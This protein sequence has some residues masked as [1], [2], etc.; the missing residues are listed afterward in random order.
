[1]PRDISG[2]YTLPVG[3]PV[4]AG[5]I[6]DVAWANPTMSDIAA[7]L[8]GVLTRDGT[9]AATNPIKFANGAVGAPSITF[10]SDAAMGFYRI[11][12][13]ILGVATAGT[14]R[15]RIDASGVSTFAGV[16]R[17]GSG[18]VSAPGLAFGAE[19]NTGM[20]LGSDNGIRFSR[21]GVD[22]LSISDG[23]SDTRLAFYGTAGN[24]S[25]STT[26]VID[27]TSTTMYFDT[28]VGISK[29]VGEDQVRAFNTA[30][31]YIIGRRDLVVQPLSSGYLAQSVLTNPTG[32]TSI[33]LP[34]TL[35]VGTQFQI[36]NDYDVNVSIP[37]PSGY[38]M[39]WLPSGGVGTR[40]LAVWGSATITYVSASRV[41]IQGVG[42]T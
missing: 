30:G 29:T 9:L 23:I 26:T 2:N 40:T 11:G 34:T 25:R 41:T 7:Q 32:L 17:I 19:T 10:N 36:L 31:D 3:N 1:M 21:A 33:T 24:V 6:I 42:I 20:Y 4:V 16:V 13:N 27:G 35:G 22:S 14:E 39:V 28:S 37:A 12:T 38:Q 5:T 18:T 15:L 8:N